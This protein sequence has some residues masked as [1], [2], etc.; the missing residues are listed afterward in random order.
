MYKTLVVAPS[1]D[2]V[3]AGDNYDVIT[4]EQ[5]LQDYPKKN[6]PK[7]RVINLCDTEHYLSQGYYCSLL[8]EAR[9]HKVLPSV[10][11]INDL[12]HL[13]SNSDSALVFSSDLVQ[14]AMDEP[15]DVYAFFGYVELDGLK[16]LARRVY[17]KYPA[18][19]IKLSLTIEGTG[20]H[21]SVSRCAYSELPIALHSLFMKKL[22][23]YTQRIWRQSA[24]QRK[25]RWD[26][27][28]LVNPEESHPPSDKDAISRFIKAAAKVGINAHTITAKEANHI[29][30]YDALFI[31]ETTAIDHH[32]YRIARKAEQ[33]G[34]VVI[35]DST[36]IMRCCNKAFLHDAF[37]YN[38][39]P[40]PKTQVVIS[41]EPGSIEQIE[42]A[43]SYPMVLKL[44]EGAFSKG[45]FKVKDRGELIHQ[46]DDLLK[47]TALVLVQ[48]YLYTDFD[49]RIGV[50]NGRAIY[51]CRYHMARNHWQIYNHGSKRFSS[52]GFETLPTFEVPK[53]VLDA[54]IKSCSIIGKGLYGVDIKQKGKQ[55]YVIEVNDNPSID[56]KVEDAYLG[57]ELYM[58]IMTEFAARLEK[59]GR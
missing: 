51:A 5:Y 25:L 8:A 53:K 37:S 57:N 12:R 4:F 13:A 7:T 46:L 1:I 48:E 17:D 16:K 54:A 29:A 36:S 41:T 55:V 11:T 3:L 40:S 27:A 45:V 33:E 10:S 18:P 38:K 24:S 30:Q 58:H 50:L 43:F 56:H 34:L 47:G 9:Q 49:W 21:L 20:L 42:A 26:M 39:V 6:E 23:E 28:I 32:T 59:R 52:G 14:L 19:I 15:L 22:N 2:A 31:R 44:P 35:D